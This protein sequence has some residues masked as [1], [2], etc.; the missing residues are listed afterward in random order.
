MQGEKRRD[1]EK[2]VIKGFLGPLGSVKE[3]VKDGGM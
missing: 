2:A 1:H 3:M